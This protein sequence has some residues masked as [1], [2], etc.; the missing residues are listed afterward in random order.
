MAQALFAK[1]LKDS[2]TEARER[3]VDNSGGHKI[4]IE[5][6]YEH[7][8]MTGGSTEADHHHDTFDY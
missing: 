8:I 6:F 2:R 3:R 1:K 5:P 4:S 7:V